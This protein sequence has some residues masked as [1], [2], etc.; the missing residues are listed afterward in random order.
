MINLQSVL[1]RNDTNFLASALGN[2]TVMMNMKT[3]DYLGLNEVSSDIWKL[4]QH[5]LT[6]EDIINTLLQRYE[7]SREDCESQTLSCLSKM[8]EQ[9][10][11]SIT[12]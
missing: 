7:V 5:P 3:G 10:M 12:H 8:A 11:I 9:G 1:Q 6:P 2:E 4:L